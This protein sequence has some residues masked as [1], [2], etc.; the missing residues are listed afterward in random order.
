[1]CNAGLPLCATAFLIA[2]STEQG[3]YEGRKGRESIKSRTDAWEFIG[4]S[5][6]WGGVENQ[7]VTCNGRISLPLRR[8]GWGPPPPAEA[9]AAQ[10]SRP[11]GPGVISWR[12]HA[13]TT[14]T[15]QEGFRDLQII[16]H[17]YVCPRSLL[18]L[19][20][21]IVDRRK[22]F[23]GISRRAVL[24]SPFSSLRPETDFG[25]VV[26]EPGPCRHNS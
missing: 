10:L 5:S 4:S 22:P 18:R 3:K 8:G 14:R 23:R 13:R 1:M 24:C 7:Q 11:A 21:S 19:P 6:W 16:Q 26:T 20:C 17:D 12:L 2:A 9:A 15:E 25:C